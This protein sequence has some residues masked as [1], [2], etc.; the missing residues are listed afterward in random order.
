MN[1][2]KTSTYVILLRGVN[3]GGN[4]LLPMK[5]LKNELEAAGFDGVKTYIQ[6]GNIVL[7]SNANPEQRVFDLISSHF[8]ITPDVLV[9]SSKEFMAAASENPYSHY[10]G[11]FV[12]LYFCKSKPHVDRAKLKSKKAET[13]TYQLSGKV[14]YLHTPEGMARSKLAAGIAG[15]LGVSVT[16]RNLNTVNKLVDMLEAVDS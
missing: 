11:K 13:E 6:S 3:V 15:C 10:E 12:H 2:Q 16:G 8:S 4:N 5:S 7:R 9:L 1:A 14:F